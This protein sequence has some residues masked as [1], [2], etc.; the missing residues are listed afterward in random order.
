MRKVS[1]ASGYRNNRFW[2][3]GGEE[4]QRM[5]VCRL[6]KVNKKKKLKV[7]EVYKGSVGEGC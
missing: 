7:M 3:G 2:F 5:L 4:V 6:H 1:E